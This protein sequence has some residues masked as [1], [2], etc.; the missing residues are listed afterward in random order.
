MNH[1]L[2]SYRWLA[3]AAMAAAVS[4]PAAAQSK[5]TLGTPKQEWAITS[6]VPTASAARS[7]A[8]SDGKIYT[9]SNGSAATMYYTDLNSKNSPRS[10]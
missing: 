10:P 5:W 3:V 1:R 8:V 4:V 2:L 6:G 9:L 7:M